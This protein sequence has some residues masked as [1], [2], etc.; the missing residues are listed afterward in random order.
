LGVI[1]NLEPEHYQYKRIYE[2]VRIKLKYKNNE[3]SFELKVE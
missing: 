2:N 1:S 3:N